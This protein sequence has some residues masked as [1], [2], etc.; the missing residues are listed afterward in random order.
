MADNTN[1]NQLHPGVYGTTTSNSSTYNTTSGVMTLFQ[2]DTFEKGPDN[3]VGFVTSVEEFLFKYGNPDFT[4]YGQGAYNVIDFLESGGQAYIMRVLPDDASFAHAILNIQ[5]KVN[6]AGKT[7]KT[8]S[9]EVVKID[10]VSIRPTTAFIQKNNKDITVLGTELDKDRSGENTVDGYEN[11]FLMLVTPNGRGESYNNLGFRIS[12]N[13]SFDSSYN[14]R[15]YNFE[16]VEYDNNGDM[17]IVEGPFYVTFDEDALNDNRESMYIESVIN[18]RSEYVNVKFSQ[19]VYAKLAKTI[20]PYVSPSAIDV[21]SGK[22]KVLSNGKISTYYDSRLKSDVDIHIALNKYNSNGDQVTRSGQPVK[23]ISETSDSVQKALISLDN[24]LRENEYI[25]SS[26]KLGYMKEQFAKLRSEEFNEF[27]LYVDSLLTVTAAHEETPESMTGKIATLI[28]NVFDEKTPT[29]IYAKYLIARD[30]AVSTPN[31]ENY[32]V[33]N[34]YVNQL[35]S[36]IKDVLTDYTNQLSAAYTLVEHNSP[37]PQLSTEYASEVNLINK[38][39]SQKDQVSIFSVE[40][41]SKIFSIQED[42]VSYQLGTASGSYKEGMSLLASST[43]DEITY[44]YESLLPVAYGSLDSVPSEIKSL[45]NNTT[46]GGIAKLYNEVS[47]LISDIKA[48]ILEDNAENRDKVFSTLNNISNQLVG[49]IDKVVFES[50]KKNIESAKSQ[51]IDNLLDCSK[52][53]VS[54]IKSMINLQ[55]TYDEEALLENARQQIQVESSGVAGLSSRFFN[56]NLIDFESPVK[57]L[58]GSDGSLTY[59]QY[60]TNRERS[61]IIK[62]LLIK[63]YSGTLNND[64]LDTDIYRFSVVFDAGYHA[65]VKKAILELARTIRQDFVFI[66]DDVDNGQFT[67]SPQE[68]IEWRQSVFNVDSYYT[69]LFSQG[70]SYYDEYTGKD[71][72]FSVPKSIA[73]KLPKQSVEIGLHYPIA[74]PRR[75]VIDGFK[76]VTWMPN[77]AY[78]EKL[79]INKINYLQT[80]SS[81]TFIGSQSTAVSNNGPLSNL[82]NQFTIL[83]MKRKVKDVLGRYIFEFN[84]DETVNDVYTEVNQLL[85]TYVS[86]RSCETATA[87]VS[88]TDYEKQQRILRVSVSVKFTDVIERIVFNISTED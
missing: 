84:D 29:S 12:V 76:G 54:A 56:T 55:G 68:S 57:L 66:A 43:E 67:V 26:N 70:L 24:G 22:S 30:N 86:N 3:E 13:S 78:R 27:K 37:N 74:G 46:E 33:F 71:L 34:S 82:N 58:L 14:W 60:T 44:V 69:A 11:N 51:V 59:N 36:S 39:L 21:I 10:D 87:T 47:S 52:Q 50:N 65:D 16:V 6:V 19:K 42:I 83:D 48:G 18:R 17:S 38:T 79:Y 5:S 41:K 64:I 2:A 32:N 8:E 53:F 85:S 23:N 20:N 7:V 80:D 81:K 31:E 61:E 45:F 25:V 63:A 4:K 75:G 40:H 28:T 72:V 73:G 35:S 49:V 88:R 77:S 15:V 1:V 62:D 9:G